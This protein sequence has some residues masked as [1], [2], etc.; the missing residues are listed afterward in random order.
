MA[1]IETESERQSW[2]TGEPPVDTVSTKGVWRV[3]EATNPHPN[4]KVFELLD[5]ALAH[6]RLATKRNWSLPIAV[7]DRND[8]IDYLFLCGEVFR[9]T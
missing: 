5:D 1:D 6:A 4:D 7:W 3:G 9:R 8:D 2:R